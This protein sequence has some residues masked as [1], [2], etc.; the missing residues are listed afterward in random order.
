MASTENLDDRALFFI[1]PLFQDRSRDIFLPARS[2]VIGSKHPG[3]YDL[4]VQVL[5]CAG[6]H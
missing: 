4:A 3:E 2:G 1:F 6:R 5:L